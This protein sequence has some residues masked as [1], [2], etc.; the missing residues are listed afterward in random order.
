[1]FG[2]STKANRFLRIFW[3]KIYQSPFGLFFL[4]SKT[5]IMEGVRH[6]HHWKLP[7]Y[8]DFPMHHTRL[9]GVPFQLPGCLISG[10]SRKCDIWT[11]LEI[12][13]FSQK[14]WF[15][16]QHLPHKQ[17]A[18]S[19][20]PCLFCCVSNHNSWSEAFVNTSRGFRVNSMHFAPNTPEIPQQF[21]AWPLPPETSIT[22]WNS[23]IF[24]QRI[25]WYKLIRWFPKWI[26]HDANPP[27]LG[28][29]TTTQNATN[30][31]IQRQTTRR[32]TPHKGFKVW[33]HLP[34]SFWRCQEWPTH[35]L[36]TIVFMFPSRI[37]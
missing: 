35:E 4:P 20:L 25:T 29:G 9:A 3:V 27:V 13:D 16:N 1:M 23:W 34:E 33:W 17:T 6:F 15:I 12:S 32:S 37:E 11:W 28:Q 19:S 31:K 14:N 2:T 26:D 21:M 10:F 30:V 18:W 7:R 36:W 24:H 22:G 8:W 5:W